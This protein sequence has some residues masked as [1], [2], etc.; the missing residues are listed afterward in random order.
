VPKFCMFHKRGLHTK[1]RSC[2]ALLAAVSR[3][4]TLWDVTKKRHRVPP[5]SPSVRPRNP[6]PKTRLGLKRQVIYFQL[7][8]DI[9]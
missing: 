4:S 5:P 6:W 9:L 2:M 8:K 1:L 7:E 3:I